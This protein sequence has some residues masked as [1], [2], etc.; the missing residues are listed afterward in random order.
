[1]RA[2]TIAPGAIRISSPVISPSASPSILAG[3]LK[4]NLPE[5]LVPLLM[6]D[7]NFP[8]TIAD[9]D[10]APATNCGIQ[11][12]PENRYEAT[13]TKGSFPLGSVPPRRTFTKFLPVLSIFVVCI[14]LFTVVTSS[15]QTP[16]P[17]GRTQS[18]RSEA[19]IESGVYGFSGGKV[20]GADF[21]EGVIG[22]CIWVFDQANK[23]QIAKGICSEKAPGRFRVVLKP[24]HYVVRGPGGDKRIELKV[25]QWVKI[26]SITLLPAGP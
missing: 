22:E 4:F 12:C 3:S 2:V 16:R 9:I 19:P 11:L 23:R 26:D 24:G 6:Q 13:P 5:T 21:P 7:S 18:N 17:A 15:P 10:T 1:M 25:G 8:S 14:V 20:P